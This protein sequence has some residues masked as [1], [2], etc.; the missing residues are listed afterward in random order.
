MPTASPSSHSATP[1]SEVS[2]SV[3]PSAAGTTTYP[4]SQNGEGAFKGNG[5]ASSLL[6]VV[7]K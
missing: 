3:P 2:Q 7:S 6:K 5:D 1:N 4:E